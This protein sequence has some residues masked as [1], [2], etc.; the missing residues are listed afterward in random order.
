MGRGR[1][2]VERMP[3][4]RT[5]DRPTQDRDI[6]I[7]RARAMAQLRHEI[8]SA[9]KDRPSYSELIDRLQ[10]AGIT[11][12]PSIQKSGRLNGM[13]YDCRGARFKGSELGRAYTAAGLSKFKGVSYDS[14][15]DDP[16]L[17]EAA[18]RGR[19]L[20]ERTVQREPNLRER[21]VLAR[22]YDSLNDS[23]RAVMREVG[24]FRAILADDLVRIQYGGDRRHFQQEI[25][26]LG[27]QGLVETQSVVIATH[28]RKHQTQTRALEV[29]VLTKKG[30]DMVRR[31]DRHTRD[32]AQV[33]YAGSVKPREIAHDAAIYRMYQAEAR[34]LTKQGARIKRVVLDF[35][36]KKKAYS[37]LAKAR[38]HSMEEYRKKQAEIAHANGL[39]VVGGKI[40][41]PD[42]RIEYETANGDA[43]R[44]DLELATEHYRGDHM[45]AKEGAGFKIYADSRSFPPGGSYGRSS[46]WD[47]H[48]IEIFS[49]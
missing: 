25:T 38:A 17:K 36:L 33:M 9:A 30:K 32:A 5:I 40:R 2:D 28:D 20:Q 3:D 43:A 49:F 19:Q 44:V 1:D 46:V 8:D 24:R 42:L 13:S 21:S 10:N 6:P 48:E 45:A 23:E 12:V 27:A 4:E 26:R 35:E 18:E 11:C 31:Y 47:D 7:H 29:A 22:E 37:P 41:L 15:R 39:N 16:R 34:H 14:E